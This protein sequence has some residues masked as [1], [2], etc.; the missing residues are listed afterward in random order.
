MFVLCGKYN[1]RL[2]L[3]KDQLLSAQDDSGSCSNLS[4]T[5][6]S[7]LCHCALS[8]HDTE[9]HV[10]TDMSGK[11]KDPHSDM[12]PLPGHILYCW[13]KSCVN[14]IQHVAVNANN[15]MLSFLGTISFSICEQRR[16]NKMLI[17]FIYIGR[18]MFMYWSAI[19]KFR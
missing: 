4:L 7:A 13:T 16:C 11:D 2:L 8:S 3:F 17:I 6:P 12:C 14:N 1:D 15:C 18:P 5:Q 19:T 10:H 9:T